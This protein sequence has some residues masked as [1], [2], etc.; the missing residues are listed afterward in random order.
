MMIFS[1]L[2]I[3]SSCK[4]EEEIIEGCTDSAAMNYNSNATSNNGSCQ[5]AYEIAQ[6][7]W[8]ISPDCEE[9]TIPVIGTIS[10]NDQLPTSIDVQAGEDNTVYLDIDG[11]EV[12]G[13]IDNAGYVIVPEQ[14]I[15][16][17]DL[18]IPTDVTVSGSGRIES[19]TA[20]SMDLTYAFEIPL[21]G[22]QNISCQIILSK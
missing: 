2:F 12:F 15:Q 17:L 18:P 1:S 16:F 13:N 4:K 9:I 14:T 21:V 6:G 22:A 7:V 20:G 11:T 5:Y 8:N 19:K 3:M 10:L